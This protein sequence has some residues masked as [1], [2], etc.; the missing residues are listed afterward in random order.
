MAHATHSW[1][2]LWTDC[3]ELPIVVVSAV[4]KSFPDATCN[5]LRY[6]AEDC[7][8]EKVSTFVQVI[9]H[10]DGSLNCYG[11]EP[12]AEYE[13]S[14]NYRGQTSLFYAKH[15]INVKFKQD[16]EFLGLPQEK[17]FVLNGPFMDCSLLRN[18]LAHWLFR[19]T[20]RYSPRTKHVVLYFKDR[21][22][23]TKPRYVGIYLLLEKITYGPS[24]TNLATMD[25]Q[26]TDE[27]DMTGG[28][29]WQ[30]DP[31]S[32]GA[33]SPNVVVDQYQNEFG[34]GE[35]PLL[36]Y[37]S[38]QDMSQKMRDYFVGTTTGFLPQLYRFMWNNMT[39]PDGLEAHLDLGSFADYILHTEMSLNVDAYRRSTYFFKDR[40]QTINAGPVWDLNLAYGN[41]ARRNFQNWI[42]PQYTFWKRLMCN[43]KLTSL[44]IQRWKDLRSEGGAWSDASI[45]AF[46]EDSAAPVRR[47]LSKC[48]SDWQSE[49]PQCA[50]VDFKTCNG[51]YEE[52]MESMKQAVLTRSRWMDEHITQLYKPLDALT[53]SGVGD[54][55]KYNCAVDGDDDGCLREPEKYYYA[56]K[57][58]AI[59]TPYSG[60]SC[61]EKRLAKSTAAYKLTPYEEPSVDNCWQ[62]AG[63]YVYPE[64]KGVRE[65]L[66]HFC[67]GYGSC[68]QGPG[69]TCNCSR[70]IDLVPS[71]CRRIDAE[72]TG[73][74]TN[75]QNV[76]Q[77]T[78]SQEITWTPFL[79]QAGIGVF[80]VGC[81]ALVAMKV[82]AQRRR[83]RM[84]VYR[85][86]LYGSTD[87]YNQ[88][89]RPR[90]DI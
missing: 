48:H 51:T 23:M 20:G 19:N 46:L 36:A 83:Q 68:S 31:L 90:N 65:N 45:D 72:F 38:G 27:S 74:A 39:N 53:C 25:T 89:T 3:F 15:A 4:T 18:H 71:S 62:S 78:K 13:A 40:E 44:V 56:V 35:R 73:S 12:T 43:Y 81:V 28:W 1:C 9:D 64:Q 58:P 79:Q 59:R 57:F 49:A 86:V 76:Q 5:Q 77:G 17:N 80:I 26:C 82:Q 66:T 75:L 87:V 29:A 32:Y 16:T 11:D 14:S 54:I 34:M 22:D 47:Q 41:G 85:P 33:Y 50:A 8:K 10:T 69:A 70:G 55:P 67:N 37:P 84:N 21:V 61:K 6:P 52:R 60:P 88:F 42:F 30:N 2:L 24:R 63:I 7:L